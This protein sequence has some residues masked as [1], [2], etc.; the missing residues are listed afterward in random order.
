[1]AD[2]IPRLAATQCDNGSFRPFARSQGLPENLL[3]VNRRPFSS[4]RRPCLISFH[5]RTVTHDLSCFAPSFILVCANENSRGPP[6]SDNDSSSS[7]FS[8]SATIRLR[9]ALASDML[10]TRSP[11]GNKTEKSAF[12]KP[13][14][15]RSQINLQ[16]GKSKNLF[17]LGFSLFSGFAFQ[18]FDVGQV[19]RPRGHEFVL[20][21]VF[22]ESTATG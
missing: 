7:S 1:M 11:F 12:R 3:K 10:R 18:R 4:C 5:Q 8:Q 2:E 6:I 22:S 9:W 15:T 19:L 17:W 16:L 14:Q 20:D 13:N 21:Q